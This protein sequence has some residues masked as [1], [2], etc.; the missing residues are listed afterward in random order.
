MG[1][2]VAE[3]V[4]PNQCSDPSTVF[5]DTIVLGVDLIGFDTGQHKDIG[6][7]MRKKEVEKAIRDAVDAE[8]KKLLK[9]RMKGNV[10]ND[11][12]QTALKDAG[13]GVGGAVTHHAKDKLGRW[14][15]CTWKHS[16]LGVWIDENNWVLYIVVPVL[17]GA[18]GVAA[19]FMYDARVGDLPASL[20]A[21]LLK[22]HLKY[23]PLGHLELGL[24][25]VHFVPSKQEVELRFLSTV[26][27][28][29]F[30]AKFTVGG[31]TLEGK[32]TKFNAS[33]EISFKNVGS[34]SNI[35]LSF[36]TFVDY[37][38][39]SL[40]M[41]GSAKAKYKTKIA[42]IPIGVGAEGTWKTTLTPGAGHTSESALMFSLSADI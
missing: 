4:A 42:D 37:S 41:G 23:K 7:A 14:A 19:G 38:D 6:R 3:G 21:P 40:S 26:D 9:A 1:N 22:K 25:K 16:P 17:A 8:T 33:S 11:K 12:A 13:K 18:G 32:P 15:E 35:E 39:P 31:G 2:G 5:G 36:K 10:S 20:A 30:K 29:P 34:A 28:K 27:W 24:D